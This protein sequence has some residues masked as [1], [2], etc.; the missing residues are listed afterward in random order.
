M[1]S[2]T[3][4]DVQR[5]AKIEKNEGVRRLNEHFQ[6]NEFVGDCQ[7]QHL[8]QEFVYDVLMFAVKRGF[9][10]TAAVEVAKMSKDLLPDLKGMERDL[11][12]ES[13]AERVSLCLP[14]LSPDHRSAVFNYIAEAYTSHHRLYQ[15]YLT[16]PA[17]KPPVTQLRVEVPPEPLKLG[18]GMNASEWEKREGVRRLSEAQEENLLEIRQLREQAGQMLLQETLEATL[19]DFNRPPE[20]SLGKQE[21]ARII[22][23]VL[24]A[25][26]EKVLERMMKEAALSQELLQLKIQ[27]KTIAR[28]TDTSVTSNQQKTK[29]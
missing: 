24:Q 23:E 6:W 5:I 21:L 27:A 10:W 28:P 19:E 8:H 20:G 2:L 12:I 18:E 7:R 26:G 17:A 13:I 15:A 14:S 1:A 22:R 3:A 25:Q 4:K 29:K 16:T 9:P 11:A